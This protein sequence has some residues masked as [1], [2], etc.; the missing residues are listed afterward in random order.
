MVIQP[1]F[2]Y[3]V[4]KIDL[5]LPLIGIYD[6]PDPIKFEPLVKPKPE[7]TECIFKF[8]NDWINGKA[9]HITKK[10][11]GCG[12]CGHWLWGLENRDRESFIKFLVDQ[13]GLKESHKLMDQWLDTSNPYEA[14][15][16]NILIGPL[17]ENQ[18]QYLK[19]V[20]FFVNPDQLSVLMI[21]AQYFSKPEDTDPVIAPFGS[22]CME[23][24]PL[25][26]DLTIPQAIIGT[27]DI[28]MRKYIPA[29]ILAFTVTKPMFEKLCQ[30]DVNSYLE[31]PFL[32]NL[33]Q[34]RSGKLK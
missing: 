26:K 23:I 33:K 19:T 10:N 8:F 5:N 7:Q 15:H 30:L 27:T 14:E 34:A 21:G 20:T 22:G 12:G 24:L 28:A 9:L 32:K 4:N 2:K 17:I 11:Y 13:E 25:F 18:Y 1:N 16:P 6:A 29:E 31:K 3:L